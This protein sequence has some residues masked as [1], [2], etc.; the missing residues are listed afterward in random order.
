ME[1]LTLQMRI[2]NSNSE[3]Q[4]MMITS[5]N[6]HFTGSLRIRRPEQRD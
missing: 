1:S 3:Y 6:N 2:M 4:K 5:I